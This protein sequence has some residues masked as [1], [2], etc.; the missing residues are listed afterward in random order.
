MCDNRL[1]RKLGNFPGRNA[2]VKMNRDRDLAAMQRQS[3]QSPAASS[4]L[5]QDNTGDMEME[6]IKDHIPGHTDVAELTELAT[7][8][9]KHLSSG[10][11]SNE[12]LVAKFRFEEFVS[13]TDLVLQK[14][15]PTREFDEYGDELD[16]S[17]EDGRKY[18]ARQQQWSEFKVAMGR[19]ESNMR[20]Q[21]DEVR[22]S[23]TYLS[24]KRPELFHGRLRLLHF[25]KQ[26]VCGV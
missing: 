17:K 14:R 6:E 24:W 11:L 16:D 1:K 3:R 7:S 4:E 23:P 13:D 15:R 25:D 21:Y 9:Y 18:L 19:L 5:P 26:K 8:W 2:A 20:V 10:G 12:E 22:N